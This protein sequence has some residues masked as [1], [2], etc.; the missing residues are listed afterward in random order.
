MW[1]MKITWEILSFKLIQE[2]NK[3]VT[4]A[5]YRSCVLIRDKLTKPCLAFFGAVILFSFEHPGRLLAK[6]DSCLR[7]QPVSKVLWNG[8]EEQH[9]RSHGRI[10]RGWLWVTCGALDAFFEVFLKGWI[11]EGD[12]TRLDL[13]APSIVSFKVTEGILQLFTVI[14]QLFTGLGRLL[15]Q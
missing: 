7:A 1:R 5:T 15:S 9:W 11:P 14:L 2:Q 6:R 8:V 3:K 12:Q 10:D 13:K 4:T